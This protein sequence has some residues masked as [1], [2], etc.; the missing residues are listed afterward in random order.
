MPGHR[1][2]HIEMWS[3]VRSAWLVS[4]IG[5]FEEWLELR[6]Q[7]VLAATVASGEEWW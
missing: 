1:L 3:L 5:R 2:R 7:N 6:L 4:S